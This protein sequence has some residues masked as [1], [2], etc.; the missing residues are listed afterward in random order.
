[1]IFH[2]YRL[3]FIGIPKNASNSIFTMLSNKTDSH[4]SH[5]S[6]MDEYFNSD[7]QLITSYTSFAIVRNPYDRLVSS[8]YYNSQENRLLTQYP[9]INS[10]KR[11]IQA[12]YYYEFPE[13]SNDPSCNPQYK[14][15][16]IHKHVLVDHVLRYETLNEDWREFATTYNSNIE[17]KFKIGINL[18]KKNE[19][20]NRIQDFMSLYDTTSL[21]LTN[22]FFAKDFELFNYSMIV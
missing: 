12:L 17:N 8:Y 6:Y 2:K 1:M 19:T 16:S 9:E 11:F 7:E 15:I 14:F 10:F 20:E 13:I 18:V 3:H 4:H 5:G 21:K 22:E